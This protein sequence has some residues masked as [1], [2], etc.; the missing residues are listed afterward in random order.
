[1]NAKA[2]AV[3]SSTPLFLRRRP[4]MKNA[5]TILALLVL[6]G[7]LSSLPTA[8]GQQNERFGGST[9]VALI[10][11]PKKVTAFL[12]RGFVSKKHPVE[13][14]DYWKKSDKSAVLSTNLISKVSQL[15]LDEKTYFPFHQ[16][17]KNCIYQ[18]GIV[19][20]FSD[21]TREMDVF[22]CLECDEMIVEPDPNKDGRSASINNEID[23]SH[24]EFVRLMKQ[25]FPD[26]PEI[27]SLKE[28]E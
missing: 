20:T 9:N 21:G 13:L 23:P 22:F 17:K 8:W 18:P 16:F 24:R 5:R 27:Q 28:S 2:N 14:P 4:G 12:T 15:L 6:I 7:T 11:S 3:K 1:M 10:S 19:L 26:T 25:I